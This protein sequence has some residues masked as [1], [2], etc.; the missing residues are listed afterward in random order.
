MEIKLKLKVFIAEFVS[1]LFVLLFIYAASSKLFDFQKF[2]VQLAKSPLVAPF[3]GW[4][5]WFVPVIEI[6]VAV[7]L[8]I[9]KY[10]LIALYAAF[11]VMVSF[12]SYIIAILNFSEYIPCSCGGILQNMT[13]QQHLVFNIVFVGL[14]LVAILIYPYEKR[15]IAIEGEAE[16]LNQSRR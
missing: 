12:T 9:K 16:N 1:F 3:V 2:Q 4:I 8:T 11:T 6:S 5:I 7:L 15:A 10:Q 13:W 14:G